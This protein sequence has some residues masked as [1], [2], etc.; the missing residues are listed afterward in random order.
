METEY[1]SLENKALKQQQTIQLLEQQ[2]SAMEGHNEKQK[3]LLQS[4]QTTIADLKASVQRNESEILELKEYLLEAQRILEEKSFKLDLMANNKDDEIRELILQRDT[5]KELLRHNEADL[6]SKLSIIEDQKSRLQEHYAKLLQ[7]EMAT[8]KLQLQN[9]ELA[10]KQQILQMEIEQRNAE[11][12]NLKTQLNELLS[13][14]STSN[15]LAHELQATRLAL[16]QKEEEMESLR[17]NVSKL[18][19]TVNLYRESVSTTSTTNA[20]TTAK[21]QE[22]I[23]ELKK[24]N[25]KLKEEVKKLTVKVKK[26]REFLRTLK[27]NLTNDA[28]DKENAKAAILEKVATKDRQIAKLNDML[29]QSLKE[30]TVESVMNASILGR[31]AHE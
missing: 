1:N 26:D 19:E 8:N 4:Q 20:E 21:Y 16:S 3:D 29:E 15:P 31:S 7:S 12:T 13:P 30:V 25:H 9:D 22:Q 14:T 27:K 6:K 5:S 10:Y 24:Q 11:I 17:L 2:I 28:R 23:S 18:D